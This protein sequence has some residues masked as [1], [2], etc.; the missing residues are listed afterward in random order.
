M[1]IWKLRWRT[2]Q[3]FWR[4]TADIFFMFLFNVFHTFPWSDLEFVTRWLVRAGDLHLKH[5]RYL[6][7]FLTMGICRKSLEWFSVKS[8]FVPESSSASN[9]LLLLYRRSD[10]PFIIS[11]LQ[12]PAT[13]IRTGNHQTRACANIV[14][15][16][17]NNNLP[18]FA[19]F[20]P[21]KTLANPVTWRETCLF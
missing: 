20:G 7:V 9:C 15:I 17:G 2:F 6:L 13:S 3:R 19:N 16:M 10:S 5:K 8:E 1:K 11:P 4:R 21:R 12:L 18:T 14:P